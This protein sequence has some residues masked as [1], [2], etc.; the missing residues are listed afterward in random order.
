M[1]AFRRALVGALV[2]AN[3]GVPAASAWTV[4]SSPG[5]LTVTGAPTAPNALAVS[6]ATGGGLVVSDD[7]GALHGGVLPAGCT[8][9][10][11][12]RVQ[13]STGTP[14]SVT[15]AGGAS[16]DTLT[17][18]SSLPGVVLDGGGAADTLYAGSGG[19]VL[20]GG[21]DGDALYGGAG[22][23]SLTG[24]DGNDQLYGAD[25]ADVLDSGAGDDQLYG[26]A[27]ADTLAAGS[28]TDLVSAGTGND[29]LDGGSGNDTL[30][31]GDGDDMLT[32]STGDD[33]V[34]GQAG[35]DTSAGDDGNDALTDDDGND[36]LS[37]GDGNDMLRGGSGADA[38]G[39]GAGADD[40]DGGDQAD[41]LRGEGGDD[42][43]AGGDGNDDLDGGEGNDT[44]VGGNGADR[45]AGGPD[46]DVADYSAVTSAVR[47]SLNGVADDGIAGEADGIA[48]D[49]EMLIGG[50]GND[51]LLLGPAGG[52]LQGGPGDDALTGGPGP[53]ALDGGTGNDVLDGGLGTDAI[54][55]AAGTDTV[56]YASRT[57]PVTIALGAAGGGAPGEQDAIDASVENAIGGSSA[58]T[59][60]DAHGIVNDLH[61]GAGND[62][63]RADGD[64]LLSDVVDCGTGADMVRADTPDAVG[65]DCETVFVGARK[66]RP[67]SPPKLIV[68]ARLS[69]ASAAGIVILHVRCAM[70][71]RGVCSGT[72]ALRFRRGRAVGKGSGRVRALPGADQRVP[73][74][75]TPTS[76]RLL[77][78]HRRAVTARVHLVV[79]DT[80]GRRAVR[81]VVITV[82]PPRTKR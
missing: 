29:R 16:A 60:V 9:I 45:L 54:V 3:I 15:I 40:L 43:L 24:A 59:L 30:A 38:L 42:R 79:G 67:S 57:T 28:G 13:C 22:A 51:E 82:R 70:A 17:N 8:A 68:G 53:D 19:D 10:S 2:L 20:D 23:D 32:G 34:D 5:S 78:R 56:T 37:G 4:S 33:V 48:S 74:R 50:S 62:T 25:G 76:R 44:V 80:L 26:A 31:G 46:A 63:F 12:S 66:V 69:H 18:D 55:G 72:A 52:R 71:T 11:P 41:T 49:V 36:A 35:N 1:R 14:L 47:L 61:G 64:P 58:D 77:A 81:D 39:G 6:D 27:G 65:G 75:L 7:A 73:I 21:D